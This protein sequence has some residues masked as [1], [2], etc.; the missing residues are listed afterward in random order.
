HIRHY[1][2]LPE[3]LEGA[4]LTKEQASVIAYR[5]L[6]EHF[7]VD[8]IVLTALSAQET[9]LPHRKNWL[10]TFADTHVYPLEKG[11]ARISITISGDEVTDAKRDIHVPEAW[12]REELNNQHKRGIVS[13]IIALLWVF[14]FV[15]ILV[16]AHK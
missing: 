5:A 1:H 13:L 9:Q 12:E 11:Q 3:S 6:I 14:L 16:L 10:F 8:P 7:N 15:L 2:K 4:S